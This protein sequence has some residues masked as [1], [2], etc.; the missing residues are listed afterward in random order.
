MKTKTEIAKELNVR[1]SNLIWSD[2][3][4]NPE[5]IYKSEVGTVRGNLGYW[6]VK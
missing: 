5:T 4:I 6:V 2:N 1:E 3:C